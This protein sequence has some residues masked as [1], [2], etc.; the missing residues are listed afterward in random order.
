VI[1]SAM[2]AMKNLSEK[3]LVLRIAEGIGYPDERPIVFERICDSEAAA[4]EI[5][6]LP[7]RFR[8][9]SPNGISPPGRFVSRSPVRFID[10]QGSSSNM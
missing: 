5:A 6:R 8:P 1:Y 9:K 3:F 10:C 2:R 4:I 7:A